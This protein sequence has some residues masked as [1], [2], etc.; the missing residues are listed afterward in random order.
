[1]S[2]PIAALDRPALPAINR[3]SLQSQAKDAIVQAILNGLFMPGE[4]VIETKIAEGLMLSRST[5]R[6]A[7]QALIQEGLLVQ[8]RYRGT[9]VMPLTAAGAEELETMREALEGLAVRRAIEFATDAEIE[10]LQRRYEAAY[11]SAGN[12]DIG[13]SYRLDLA[14]HQQLVHMAHHELLAFHFKLIEPKMLLYMAHAGGPFL[15]E[16]SFQRQHRDIVQGIASR[17]P[18]RAARALNVHFTEATGFLVTLFANK[19]LG[20]QGVKADSP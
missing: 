3:D 7:I 1:M 9:I 4:R 10:E 5:V 17:D 20:T 18:E 12:K 6:A 16:K 19:E 2:Q 11:A 8:V 14:F 15:S 13:L